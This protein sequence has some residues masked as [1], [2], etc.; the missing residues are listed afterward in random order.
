MPGNL[1]AQVEEILFWETMG[2]MREVTPLPGYQSPNSI[3]MSFQVPLHID[4]FFCLLSTLEPYSTTL[5][6]YG[7]S[8]GLVGRLIHLSSIDSCSGPQF[9][10]EMAT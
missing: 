1:C 10:M 7:R 4:T 3:F 6:Q 8:V 5:A 2:R 9:F